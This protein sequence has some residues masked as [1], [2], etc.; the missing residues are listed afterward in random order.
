MSWHDLAWSVGPI[1]LTALLATWAA[2]HFVRPAPPDTI[3]I[4]TG[5]EGS[6]FRN[7][8]ERYRKILARNDV[9]LE[10]LASGGSAENLQRLNDPAVRVDLGFVQGGLASPE[11]AA[12]LV[13]LGSVFHEPLA[14][15]YRAAEPIGLLSALAGKRVAIGREGSGGRALALVLLKANG[16]EPGGATELFD[17]A[18]TAA[19]AALIDGTIDAAFFASDSATIGLMRKLVST[20][21]VRLFSFS[22][23]DAYTRRFPYL[24]KLELPAGIFDLGANNPPAPIFLIGP[25]VE[26]VAR[27]GLH[28]AL[29]DLLIEAAREVHGGASIF[30][31]AGEFPAP[32]E[33]EFRISDDASRYYKSGK[34]L[35]YRNL[36]F[37]LASLTDRLLFLLLPLLVLLIPSLR[38]VPWLYS[39]RVRSRLYRWYGELLAIERSALAHAQAV[40]HERLVA[41]LDEVESAVNRIKIPLAFADEFYVLREHIRFVRER[42]A[43]AAAAGSATG[44]A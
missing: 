31:R 32:L 21:G 12:K 10:I 3:T 25:T 16:I 26:L 1:A 43:G 29:S 40:E 23:A 41:R 28:P 20:P 27:E 2:Y 24:T 22:Q 5:T 9:K 44:A 34:G 15:F 37:W 6:L 17:D 39:W 38:L 36:P 4:T 14:V 7:T 8:A 42:L 13:S 19:A 30:R 35:L 11:A 18:G 33:H